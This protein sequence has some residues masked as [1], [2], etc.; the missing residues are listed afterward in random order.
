MNLTWQ[1]LSLSLWQSVSTSCA[2]HVC[3]SLNSVLSIVLIQVPE[4][5]GWLELE[6]V[7]GLEEEPYFAVCRSEQCVCYHQANADSYLAFLKII[8]HHE[9]VV[10]I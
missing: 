3:Q 8:V 5:E 2:R 6:A 9:G 1:V 4:R 7:C 10:V